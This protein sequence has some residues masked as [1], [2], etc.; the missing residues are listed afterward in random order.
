MK[1]S[2]FGETVAKV[3]VH[4][5][6]SAKPP[7]AAMMKALL[8]ASGKNAN[9]NKANRKGVVQF[10]VIRK[11]M[12]WINETTKVVG[13]PETAMQL[14]FEAGNEETLAEELAEKAAEKKAAEKEKNQPKGKGKGRK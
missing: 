8:K 13:T 2:K 14:T 1:K 5:S 7:P 4:S 11:D 9:L 6:H 10:I 12:T 3:L